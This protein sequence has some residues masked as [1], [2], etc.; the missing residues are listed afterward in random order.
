MVE[1]GRS[2][3]LSNAGVTR[4][5]DR[6]EQRGLVERA[7]CSHDRRVVYATLTQ[8]GRDAFDEAGPL[9]AAAAVAHLGCHLGMQEIAAMRRGLDK[10]LTAEADSPAQRSHEGTSGP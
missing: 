5:I 8:Q 6:L 9:L 10:V 2:L 7:S 1:I 3:L 4:L